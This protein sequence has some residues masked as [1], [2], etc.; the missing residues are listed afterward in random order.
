M[1]SR[2]DIFPILGMILLLVAWGVFI[3]NAVVHKPGELEEIL[4]KHIQTGGNNG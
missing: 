1:I 3:F 2:R 4:N